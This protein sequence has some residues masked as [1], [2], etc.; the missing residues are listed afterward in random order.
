M[1]GDRGV[2]R[3][4]GFFLPRYTLRRNVLILSHDMA[5]LGVK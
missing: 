1:R 5:L 2:R 3:L 4:R